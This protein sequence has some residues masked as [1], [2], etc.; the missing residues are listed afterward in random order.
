MERFNDVVH[1]RELAQGKLITILDSLEDATTL[2]WAALKTCQKEVEAAYDAY[3]TAYGQIL[4]MVPSTSR[5]E[6]DALYDAFDDLHTEV[7]TVI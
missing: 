4:G 1:Q 3:H 7:L 2:T 5:D 6:Q